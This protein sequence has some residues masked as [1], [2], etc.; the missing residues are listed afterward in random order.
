VAC[1]RALRS[2][3]SERYPKRL[4][5][6]A[7]GADLLLPA[8]ASPPKS[9]ELDLPLSSS[10]GWGVGSAGVLWVRAPWSQSGR[11]LDR[12][13][14]ARVAGAMVRPGETDQAGVGRGPG[15]EPLG[16]EALVGSRTSDPPLA[17]LPPSKP[18]P[19]AIGPSLLPTDPATRMASPGR[20]QLKEI[21]RS[22][23]DPNGHA[24]DPCNIWGRRP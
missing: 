6:E 10:G 18:P 21:L 17:A 3:G 22:L 7:G 19:V 15:L 16:S 8:N 14:P 5:P 23:S 11:L 9:R 24:S 13:A 2:G 12:A 1:V 20:V 4:H